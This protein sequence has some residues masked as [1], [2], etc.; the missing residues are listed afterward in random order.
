MTN[1]RAVCVDWGHRSEGYRMIRVILE[2][3]PGYGR[4]RYEVS[5]PDTQI[6]ALMEV[7]EVFA[8]EVPEFTA[9]FIEVD[10]QEAA[11][12]RRR[13]LVAALKDELQPGTEPSSVAG[14]WI[15]TKLNRGDKLGVVR[16]ACKAAGVQL[17]WL[18]DLELVKAALLRLRPERP[19][20]AAPR[21]AAPIE[22][23]RAAQHP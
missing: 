22:P 20:V 2:R 18:S 4:R 7:I 5:L 16:L 8:M 10:K 6:A 13:R 23:P 21:P 3:Y 17:K 14:I 12:R 15:A 19:S 1:I 11:K 9:K